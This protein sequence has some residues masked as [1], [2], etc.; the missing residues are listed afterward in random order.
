MK[1]MLFV[2]FIATT[3]ISQAIDLKPLE[4]DSAG[5]GSLSIKVY[6]SNSEV[7]IND[8]KIGRG[9]FTIKNLTSGTYRVE[10]RFEGENQQKY[11]FIEDQ[12]SSEVAFKL[13]R[14][15][16][17]YLQ[18]S[19]SHIFIKSKAIVGP[20]LDLGFKYKKQYWGINYDW[21]FGTPY[22]DYG[23]GMC[24]GGAA[25][26]WNYEVANVSD[27]LLISTGVQAGFWYADYYKDD[28]YYN[29][30]YEYFE[31]DSFSE[32]FFG[33]ITAK[34]ELGYKRVFGVIEHTL[35]FGSTIGQKLHA[36]VSVHM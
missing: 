12:S 5:K 4:I 30:S 11:C 20:A 7:F 2:A 3:A 21:T 13:A 9:N 35:L 33:G 18:T 10:A 28:Y 8:Q 6:P 15:W 26:N 16:S 22:E 17:I 1:W 31:S 36:G 32:V 29:G 34:A 14:D 25:M 23:W 19:F 24:F 27:I